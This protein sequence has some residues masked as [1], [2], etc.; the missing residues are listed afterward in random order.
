M[1][2]LF[3][4]LQALKRYPLERYAGILW[5]ATPVPI[6]ALRPVPFPAIWVVPFERYY[7]KK[8]FIFF[9]FFKDLS[10]SLISLSEVWEYNKSAGKQSANTIVNERKSNF[11]I[12]CFVTME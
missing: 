4:K 12:I 2:L 8:K 11:L 7:Q 9:S 1:K 3:K 6:G 10:N 5:S